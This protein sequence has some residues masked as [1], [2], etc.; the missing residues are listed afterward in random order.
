MKKTPPA[1][2][3]MVEAWAFMLWM[4][5]TYPRELVEFAQEYAADPNR[6]GL[7]GSNPSDSGAA[8][9]HAPHPDL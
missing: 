6:L 2:F 7:S 1:P 5:R 4:W 3:D 8:R 9:E